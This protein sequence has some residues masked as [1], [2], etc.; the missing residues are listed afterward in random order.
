MRLGRN[1][2]E[3]LLGLASPS[4]LLV[5]GDDRVARSLVRRGLLKPKKEAHPEA[6]LQI[7]PAGMRE[8]ADHFEAGE[9]EQFMKWPQVVA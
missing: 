7:T 9:L 4:M 1:Q 3:R 5:V 2:L 8:L 6:F